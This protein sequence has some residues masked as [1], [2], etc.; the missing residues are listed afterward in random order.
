MD[1]IALFDVTPEQFPWRSPR[2][3]E[4]LSRRS[5]LSNELFFDILLELG[6]IEDPHFLYPPTDTSSLQRLLDAIDASSYDSMKRNC[7]VYYLLRWH[8]DGRESKYADRKCISP[9]Y[10][11]ITDAYWHLDTGINLGV[12]GTDLDAACFII[13]NNRCFPFD[14]ELWR[15]SLMQGSSRS[16]LPRR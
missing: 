3:N 6:G 1:D 13:E 7:L 9:H 12:S 16:M 11:A 2:P 5:L 8:G 4:I 14:S 15:F 10:V